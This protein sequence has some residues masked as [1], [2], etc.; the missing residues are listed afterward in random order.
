MFCVY[1]TIYKG[2]KLP[3]FYIGYS[4]VKKIE[5]EGYHGTVKSKIYKEIWDR[6]LEKPYLFETKIISIC[7]TKEEAKIRE[8]FFQRF[9]NVHTNP[10]YINRSIQ[11]ESF[12]RKKGE[13]NHSQITKSEKWKS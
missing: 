4:S 3:P 5:E 10:M 11:G 8:T 12:Y 6:E 1:L 13:Y 2:N 9:F 7:K